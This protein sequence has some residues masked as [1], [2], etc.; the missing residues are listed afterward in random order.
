MRIVRGSVLALLLVGA[1]APVAAQAE[2]D[3]HAARREWLARRRAGELADTASVRKAPAAAEATSP[4]RAAGAAPGAAAPHRFAERF[5]P[6]HEATS[7]GFE[8]WPLEPLSPR[9]GGWWGSPYGWY[10]GAGG[11]N[12]GYGGGWQACARVTVQLAPGGRYTLYLLLPP[13]NPYDAADLELLLDRELTAGRALTLMSAEGVWVRVHPGS[14]IE[15]V[16]I[17]TCGGG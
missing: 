15:A 13:A 5:T 11:W 8:L 12:G 1:A 6:N 4:G 3:R 16:G 2:P 10:G 9:R 14:R 17:A 7:R